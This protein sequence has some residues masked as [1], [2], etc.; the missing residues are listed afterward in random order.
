MP[1][2]PFPST[3]FGDVVDPDKRR[4]LTIGQMLTSLGAGMG[5]AGAAGR[6]F[7]AGIAPGAQL[8]TQSMAEQQ[9]QDEA[10]ALRE[11]QV[12]LQGQALKDKEADRQLKLK[13]MQ[14][15]ADEFRPGMGGAQPAVSTAPATPS[16]R[17][18]SPP[19]TMG[20]GA[21]YFVTTG[22][23]E[24]GGDYNVDNKLGSGAHGKYQFMPQTWAD[25]A[26]AHPELSLP[27]DVRAATPDQQ[28]AAMRAFTADNANQIRTAGFEPTA[29][30]LGL[31]HRF[32]A[33]GAV[34]VL[35][36]PGNA[37]LSSLFP[38]QYTAQNPDMVGKTVDQFRGG[39]QQRY[40]TAQL[41]G[42][43]GDE[44]RA[45]G[46][47]TPLSPV[48][49]AAPTLADVPKPFLPE[50]DR[51]RLARL[52]AAGAITP[53]QSIAEKNRI[54]G[55]LWTQQRAQA[56]TQ[57]NQANENWRF[58]RGQQA[59][60]DRDKSKDISSFYTD[61]DV[62][63]QIKALAPADRAS[64]NAATAL[65]DHKG[66][67]AILMKGQTGISPENQDLH[68]DD[69]MKT[70]AYGDRN[71]VG[72]LV[73]GSLL[74]EDLSKRS[75]NT[76]EYNR[77]I[78]LAKQVDPDFSPGP[79]GARR[80]FEKN[81][82]VTGQG[83]QNILAAN[84]AMA[85]MGAYHDLATALS[86]GSV[87]AV[88]SVVNQLKK[89]FGDANVTNA[90]AGRM[91]LGTEIAKT[92][93]GAGSLSESEEKAAQTL[94][95]PNA[96]PAQQQGALSTLMEFMMGRVRA[97]EDRARGVGVPDKEIANYLSPRS[98]DVMERIKSN[99]IGSKPATP[100][101]NRPPLSSI[102]GSGSP[103]P[104]QRPPLNQILGAP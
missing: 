44:P 30:L 25:L 75:G 64:F 92:V 87:P 97:V 71:I 50:E 42:A 101:A 31:A 47:G 104:G 40:G 32:G 19:P 84:T 5:A 17:A 29:D 63:K 79:G 61:P 96:A 22:K 27:F 89:Q 18:V 77:L 58:T 57:Y 66:A 34:S 49:M 28:E 35:R 3:G 13:G 23:G 24:S 76:N 54:I 65:G 74:P 46:S 70:L 69:F 78:S 103:P 83:G 36:A 9:Q 80:A 21:D 26:K 41:G 15:A 67:A 85:H 53:E 33:N 1:D 62:Q 2:F 14:A 56:Q 73:D 99:P 81:F 68:G 10:R 95:D 59:K 52:L 90:Q 7:Y 39:L 16:M 20:P 37:P 72:G 88:N 60:S 11:Y 100:P 43:Q 94:I 51:A 86:N 48:P 8:F 4:L 45:D 91:L 12:G 38:A 102:F 98:R 93:R 6:P 82:M 55:D